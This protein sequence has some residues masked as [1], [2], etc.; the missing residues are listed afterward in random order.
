M[1]TSTTL[2][3]TLRWRSLSRIWGQACIAACLHLELSV[4]GKTCLMDTFWFVTPPPQSCVLWEDLIMSSVENIEERHL[5]VSA[6]ENPDIW[7]K[8]LKE[9]QLLI[10]GPALHFCLSVLYW[11][12]FVVCRIEKYSIDSYRGQ[13]HVFYLNMALSLWEGSKT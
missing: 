5:W 1:S 9:K 2:S 7:R 11:L 6:S 8:W 3:F 13:G 10:C 12:H 4:L